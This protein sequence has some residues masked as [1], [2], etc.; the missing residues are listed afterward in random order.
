MCEYPSVE[1]CPDTGVFLVPFLTDAICSYI[2]FLNGLPV[3]P[4]Y[5]LLHNLQVIR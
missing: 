2:L 5:I 3:S 1:K 4:T